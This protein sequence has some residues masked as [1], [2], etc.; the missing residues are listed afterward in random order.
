MRPHRVRAA[1]ALL[2]VLAGVLAAACADRSAPDP[3]LVL[4]T[5]D[6]FRQDHLGCAGNPVVRTPHLDRLERRGVQ[7]P[8]AVTAIPLTTPSHATILTGLSPRGHGLL[9]NRMRLDEAVPTLATRL[10][11]AGYRT[12]AVVSSGIVLGPEFGLDRGFDSYRVVESETRPA[13][14]G[15][16]LTARASLGWLGEHGGPGSF[17][18]VHFFDAHLPYL[19]PPPLGRLYAPD[20]A[21]SLDASAHAIQQDLREA[22]RVDPADVAYLRAQYA[23]EI[24]FLDASVGRILTFLEL[25]HPATTVLVT[26]DH[27]EGLYEHQRY[28]GHDVLLHETSVRVPLLLA[29]PAAPRTRFPGRLAPGPA[30]TVDVAPTLLGAAGIEP[31]TRLEGADLPAEPVREGQ[32][33]RA[34][35]ESH[36]SRG[37]SPDLYALRAPDAKVIW[38]PPGTR[39][40]YDLSE[41]PG[42]TRDLA[43]DDRADHAEML[44]HL[45]YDLRENPPG[46]A[47]TVDAE[48]GGPDAETRA[49]LESLGYVDR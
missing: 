43:A 44:R 21:G 19:P 18:W 41:D 10:A 20:Y 1:R 12:G 40:A 28:F 15:G 8:D 14:G 36:P 3:A 25:R 35:L 5:L 33:A 24:T 34:V 45:L 22:E 6:T 4:I 17:H 39:E 32:A 13:S 23:G 42:E 27:G 37:K 7:W 30:R 31:E 47:L 46:A 38:A 29:G 26:A 49:A 48:R 16:A 9:K 2:P 11:A